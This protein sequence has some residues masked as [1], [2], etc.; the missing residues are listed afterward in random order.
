METISQQIRLFLGGDGEFIRTIES[1][2]IESGTTGGSASDR[3][4]APV[5]R[6]PWR[7]RQIRHT[8]AGA[9]SIVHSADKWISPSATLK[10]HYGFGSGQTGLGW[11]REAKGLAKHLRWCQARGEKQRRHLGFLARQLVVGLS[12]PV[13]RAQKIAQELRTAPAAADPAGRRM[14]RKLIESAPLSLSLSVFVSQ[15]FRH[16]CAA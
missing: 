4:R 1:A 9:S 13:E 16:L 2:H 10:E 6:V 8:V 14:K 15:S 11:A 5:T 7:R 12:L 3:G